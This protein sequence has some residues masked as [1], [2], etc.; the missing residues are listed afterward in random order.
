MSCRTRNEAKKHMFVMISKKLF[1]ENTKFFESIGLSRY[2]FGMKNTVK[3]DLRKLKPDTISRLKD[4]CSSAKGAYGAKTAVKDIEVWQSTLS[5]SG[6]E[7]T[8][9]VRST[10]QFTSML[11]FVLSKTKRKWLFR[12]DSDGSYYPYFVRKISH[13]RR[14]IDA[15]PTC[16]I[17]LCYDDI[18]EIKSTQRNL[19]AQEVIGKTIH[20]ALADRGL[21]IETQDLIDRYQADVDEFSK[22]CDRV[23]LQ[24]MALGMGDNRV[25]SFE[26]SDK[27]G[28]SRYWGYYGH[29]YGSIGVGS[30]G[31]P[32]RVVVDV[33]HE[34]SDSEPSRSLPTDEFWKKLK[35][36]VDSSQD[37]E[38]VQED[39]DGDADDVSIAMV[40]L[41]PRVVVFDFSKG[42][43]I[44]MH[45]S[46]LTEYQYRNDI[47][48]RLVIPEDHRNLIDMLIEGNGIFSD[49]VSGKGSGA[50]ILS[51]GPPGT[52]KT[53]T[54]EVYSE[55][56]KRPLYSVQCSQLG[57]NVDDL[58]KNLGW[59]FARAS[60][61]KA[62][63]LLDEA[64][65]YVRARGEDLVQ[66]AIV[67]VFLRTLEYYD[68]VMFLT[69]NRSD[70]VDDAISSRCIARIDYTPPEPDLLRKI[71]KTLGNVSG[72][73]LSDELIDALIDEFVGISGRD[74]KNLLKLSSILAAHRKQPL[75]IEHFRFARKFKPSI[76]R[77]EANKF[78]VEYAYGWTKA[79]QKAL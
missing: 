27:K 19:S 5:G 4:I 52:G 50:I 25:S 63:L 62:I 44:A 38:Y 22:I 40:P 71:W 65:V 46:C 26:D 60:R 20:Q 77:S 72:N 12:H 17:E 30:N 1:E 69:T 9:T 70:L 13:S 61:W 78:G 14:L 49:V 11:S 35:F 18:G 37:E 39:D 58:E 51:A 74:V 75:S 67:G 79:S 29:H 53:L 2:G 56:S 54:A 41:H 68:G 10:E 59:A 7:A 66:N 73:H 45:V 42:E 64:D 15:P 43:R 23:G 24:M 57:I 33:F 48:N 6:D 8:A 28:S 47:G 16:D 3:I 36:E 31:C 32:S 21:Y 76:D 34:G 55:T